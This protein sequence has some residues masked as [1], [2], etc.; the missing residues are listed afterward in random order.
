MKAH[1]NLVFFSHQDR[2]IGQVRYCKRTLY[3]FRGFLN[4]SIAYCKRV[5][6]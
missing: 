3:L 2:E 4:V 6:G 1:K 5:K